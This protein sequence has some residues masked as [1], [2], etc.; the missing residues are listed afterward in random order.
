VGTDLIIRIFITSNL[1]DPQYQ[2]L[3]SPG[4]KTRSLSDYRTGSKEN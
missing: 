3:R 4:T 1:Q 2:K